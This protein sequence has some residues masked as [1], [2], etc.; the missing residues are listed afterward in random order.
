MSEV[1]LTAYNVKTKEKG[2]PMH[3]A[4]DHQDGQGSIYGSK[5]MMVKETS[6]QHC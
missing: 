2:V 4:V 3:D 1:T 6:L 5:V